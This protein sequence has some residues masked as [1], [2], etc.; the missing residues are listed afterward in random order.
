MTYLYIW[1]FLGDDEVD[2]P[3]APL[4][5][6]FKWRE[7]VSFVKSSLGF[8]EKGVLP[9]SRNAAISSFNAISGPLRKVYTR[10][11]YRRDPI[12]L[13]FNMCI[14]IEKSTLIFLYRPT[15]IVPA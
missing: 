7:T 9:P 6:D 8:G 12:V 3:A 1:F 13:H 14:Q 2:V 4:S 15:C 10:G 5:S 11:V